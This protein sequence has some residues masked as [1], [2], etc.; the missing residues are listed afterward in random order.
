MNFCYFSSRT[1]SGAR[2]GST[3][4]KPRFKHGV[5]IKYIFY[6]IMIILP[7]FLV[8]SYF[9]DII[10]INAKL[11]NVKKITKL[12]LCGYGEFHYHIHSVNF[13]IE[14]KRGSVI[15]IWVYNTDQGLT[16]SP[17]HFYLSRLGPWSFASGAGTVG[18][19][20]MTK[21][22]PLESSYWAHGLTSVRRVTLRQCFL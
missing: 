19:H 2:R 8:Y 6:G 10:W 1:K 4:R 20:E 12:N 13:E 3:V 7:V 17:Q 15:R 21:G 9:R 18:E 11:W 5:A 16:G 22:E 14:G